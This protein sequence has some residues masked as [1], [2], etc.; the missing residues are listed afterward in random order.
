MYNKVIQVYIYIYMY[1]YVYVREDKSF[2]VVFI[3]WGN[4][5]IYI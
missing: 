5:T 4:E 3:T 2:Q 1:V